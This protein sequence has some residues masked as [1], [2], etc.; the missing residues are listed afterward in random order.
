MFLSSLVPAL[1]LMFGVVLRTSC[2]SRR[3]PGCGAE[4]SK[5]CASNTCGAYR[6]TFFAAIFFPALVARF[7]E[8]VN[9][10]DRR[11]AVAESIARALA[12]SHPPSQVRAYGLRSL[13]PMTCRSRRPS[14]CDGDP[15]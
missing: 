7:V 15:Q 12:A 5:R 11:F 4:A 2:K 9:I 3:S 13:R 14:T 10:L 1:F 8:P 6:R